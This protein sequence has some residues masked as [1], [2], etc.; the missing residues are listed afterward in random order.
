[1]PRQHGRQRHHC[2]R[3]LCRDGRHYLQRRRHVF[4][5]VGADQDWRGGPGLLCRHGDRMV[6]GR[7]RWFRGGQLDAQRL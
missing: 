1:M 7:R 3:K 6:P 5:A 4:A 2:G